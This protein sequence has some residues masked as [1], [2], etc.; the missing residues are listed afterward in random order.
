[1]QE[2]Y[3]H[4]LSSSIEL[5]LSLFPKGLHWDDVRVEAW[6]EEALL[7]QMYLPTFLRRQKRVHVK[8][9]GW[10]HPVYWLPIS[11]VNACP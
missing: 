3:K 7:S 6:S 2:T 5:G 9:G 4:L 1:M 11:K 8:P 10:F